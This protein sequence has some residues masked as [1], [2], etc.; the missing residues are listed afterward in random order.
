MTKLVLSL[1]LALVLSA[2]GGT[3]T[4]D[5]G[6]VSTADDRTWGP[7]AVVPADRVGMEA[8][9]EG[10]LEVTD[11]CVLLDEQGEDVLLMWDAGQTRW[12]PDERTITV[13][14]RDGT[15]TVGD[16]DEVR[17]GGGGSSVTEGGVASGEWAA[18]I[19]WV[20]PPASTCLTDARWS[21]DGVER[22]ADGS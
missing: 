5:V 21:V 6:D 18:G 17:L 12:N 19:D 3:A 1:S 9:I 8:L 7:L 16:G 13:E 10:T 22:I 14:G 15:V 20:S 11:Q 4:T 2:C